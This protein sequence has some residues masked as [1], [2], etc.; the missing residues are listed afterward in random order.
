MAISIPLGGKLTL[1]SLFIRSVSARRTRFAV[2]VTV[3]ALAVTVPGSIEG[4]P[5]DTRASRIDQPRAI[6]VAL[7]RF[8]KTWMLDPFPRIPG[9]LGCEIPGGGLAGGSFKGMCQTRVTKGR[10]FITVAFTE[11][12]DSSTFNGDGVPPHTP[13]SHTWLVTES[14]KLV[15]LDASTF[16][17]FPPQWVR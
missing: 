15:A 6:R 5:V 16:G 1:V 2:V 8:G 7:A 10:R 13:L 12:W 17:D 11:T 3:I 4:S 9:R 14:L